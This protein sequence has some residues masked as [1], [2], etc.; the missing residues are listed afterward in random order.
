MKYSIL[1]ALVFGSVVVLADQAYPAASST[2]TAYDTVA[3]DSS[4]M[5]I[6][7]TEPPT[8]SPSPPPHHGCEGHCGGKC[9]DGIVQ[10]PEEECD[11]GIEL[12]VSLSG[13]IGSPNK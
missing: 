3:S 2:V 4:T 5:T 1:S 6:S 13:Q 7:Y 12:N 11:L 9:G 10:S 8:H